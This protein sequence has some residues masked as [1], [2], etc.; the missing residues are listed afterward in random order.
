MVAAVVSLALEWPRHP[1]DGWIEGTAILVACFIV[2]AVTATNDYSK[3]KQFRELNAVKDDIDVKVIRGGK[4]IQV[5]TKELLV[6]DIVLLESG[7]KIPGD[8]LYISGDDCESNEASL[9]G[10]P[11]DL[12]KNQKKDPFLLSGCQ[13]T[14]GFC[15]MVLIAVGDESRWG[16]IKLA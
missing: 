8:G 2:S 4:Q 9:T 16:R 11:V 3:E 14:A 10:E 7:D 12:K 6:G 15:K 1:K 5:S 13:V